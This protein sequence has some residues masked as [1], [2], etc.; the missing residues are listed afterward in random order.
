ML[1]VVAVLA[2][3][4]SL[5]GVGMLLFGTPILL[6]MDFAFRDALCLLLPA[7]L[8]ISLLQLIIDRG[9]DRYSIGKFFLSAGP[10]LVIGL[11]VSLAGL[12]KVKV[13][14]IVAALLMASSLL[15]LSPRLGQFVKAL[16][17]RNEHGALAVIGLV[18]GMT[19]MGGSLLAIYAATRFGEKI[20]I[21]QNIALGYA[22]FAATQL[23]TLLLTYPQGFHGWLAYATVAGAVF[24]VV[25][26]A[27]FKGLSH[28]SF[29][30][31][32]CVFMMIC[33]VLLI[34]KSLHPEI[35]NMRILS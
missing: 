34:T 7:S 23:L 3:V 4:Q 13:D 30:G 29:Q 9:V 18:H 1:T 12:M 15:R 17:D 22:V 35:F 8:T 25:G 14:L 32:M 26:R 19:N 6:M 16:M 33:A 11:F 24:L 5:F 31:L 10:F 21:R 2:L 28:R 27:T 20:A